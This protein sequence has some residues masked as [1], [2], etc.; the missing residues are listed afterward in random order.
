MDALPNYLML[1]YAEISR[2]F[3]SELYEREKL[4]TFQ[5]A[6]KV[7]CC[8]ATIWKKL[9]YYGITPRL[10]GTERVN[11]TKKQLESL[12]TNKKLSTWQIG[13]K[14][15]IPRSTIYRKLKE[16][17]V[18]IRDRATSHII[19]PRKN[20]SGNL[21]E[22]AYLIGFRIGDLGVRKIYPNSKTITIASGSTI[23]EQIE[24]IN[25]LFKKYGKVWIKEA[26]NNKINIY[27][28][29]NESF[30]FL[31]S[32]TFPGWIKKDRNSFF[33]F[34]AGF[35]DAE[36]TISQNNKLDYYSLGNYDNGLLFMIYKTL[37]KFGIKCNKP[38]HDNRKG[39][40]NS[41]GYTYKSNYWSL[42][43]YAKKDLLNLLL[44][45]KPYIQHK[46]KVKALNTAILSIK[47][48]NRLNN[49]R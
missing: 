42:R 22:K 8:Q 29:L 16:F 33:P 17:D 13:E 32:K 5:I 46:N 6:E 28:L 34:L 12:Y 38:T 44:E 14:F 49:L 20:F 3:L 1:K 47:L 37:N 43:I 25:N 30:D 48:R 35:T 4:T 7:G 31:L 21:I 39:K 9:N 24:L 27:S 18:T 26:K 19:Y 15:G 40:T 23:K 36:G 2:E 45:L 10:P 41:Q 11:I